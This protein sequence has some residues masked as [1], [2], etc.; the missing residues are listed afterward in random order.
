MIEF[1]LKLLESNLHSKLRQ[2]NQEPNKIKFH[3][4]GGMWTESLASEKIL[5]QIFSILQNFEKIAELGHIFTGSA[6]TIRDEKSGQHFPAVTNIGF[7]LETHQIFYLDVTEINL[8]LGQEDIFG[9]NQRSS[10][11]WY[12]FFSGVDALGLS[13]DRSAENDKISKSKL[14]DQDCAEI[15]SFSAQNPRCESKNSQI[16][17]I[18]HQYNLVFYQGQIF[19]PEQKF[20]QLDAR[21][22]SILRSGLV[23]FLEKNI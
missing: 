4:I 10:R 14:M 21:T 16:C 15:N 19:I 3:I 23:D 18:F 2:A 20:D 13:D 12:N 6:A 22:E 7:N 11:L 1:C 17:R 9:Y 8:T 5:Q